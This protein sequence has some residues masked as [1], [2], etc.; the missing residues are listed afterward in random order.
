[1][2]APWKKS[3]DKPRTHIEKQEHNFAYKCLYSQSYDFSSHHVWMW[4]L[5]NRKGWVPKNRCFWTV[6]LEKTLESPWTARR[7][8]QSI[9]KEINPDIHWKD[10]CW[11]WSSNT[12]HLMWRADSLEKT[13]YW[14]RLMTGGEGVDRGW[15]VGWHHWPNEQESEKTGR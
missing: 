8:N 1:M 4:V 6:V 13:R 12:G 11:N 10:W 3:N 14:E 5:D 7:S 9:L 2:L 15:D